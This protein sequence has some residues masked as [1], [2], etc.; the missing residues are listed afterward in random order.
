LRIIQL[1]KDYSSTGGIATY[2]LQLCSALEAAGHEVIVIHADPKAAP[3]PA[4]VSRQ[5]YVKEFDRF[6]SDGQGGRT[7][8]EVIE[9][10]ETVDPDLVHIQANN[11]FML[12]AEIRRRFPAIKSLHVY[13]YCPSGNK[14]HHALGQTCHHPTGPLCVAR[15]GYK[16]CLLSK[17]PSVI[18][19]HYQRCVE[20]NRNNAQYLKL[21]VASEY[22][23]QQAVATGYRP[24]Q[25]EVLPYFTELPALSPGES[26]GRKTVKFVGRVVR[27][28]GL[29]RLLSAL[30]LVRTPWRLVVD[31]DGMDL[32]RVKR[33]ARRLGLEDRV[34]FVGWA[35]RAAHLNLYRDASVVV[36]P[37][38]WP[39]PFG[40][41]GIEA[42]SYGKPVVAF[43]VGGIPEWLE[44]N[45]TGFLVTPH[46]VNQMAEKIEFLLEH[47]DVAREMGMKGRD[48]V[49]REFTGQQH[50]ARLLDIYQEVMEC[51]QRVCY[52]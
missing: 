16:R 23:K 48:R 1:S 47:P 20:A 31:G 3:V 19:W 8:S 41:V 42:M 29:D 9:V 14:F 32:P 13:D 27:E 17:R 38:M 4:G 46:D 7:A 35:D 43:R 50:V 18:W 45:V 37:S 21:I 2:V 28:K 5:F 24:E 6:T 33:L 22:V 51:T 36:V 26:D 10:L 40:I 12:E 49:E 52:S 15:M 39:E 11:N 30:R 34:E 25:I 44:D